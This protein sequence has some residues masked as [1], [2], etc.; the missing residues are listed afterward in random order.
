[1]PD[2]T[3]VVHEPGERA[4]S[5]TE[6][7]A[8]S[9][10]DAGSGADLAAWALILGG[11]VIVLFGA[12]FVVAI[13]GFAVGLELGA[14]IVVPAVAAQVAFVFVAW[15]VVDRDRATRNTVIT[16]LMVGGVLF[17]LGLGA[18]DVGDTSI[19]GRHYQGE[20]IH[21]LVDGWNPLRDPALQFRHRDPDIWTNSYPK[22]T[23]VLQ[24][25]VM[26]VGGDFEST[27]L[28]GAAL[29]AAS[30]LIA[31]A[32]FAEAG[33]NRVGATAG[34]LV[35]ALNPVATFELGTHMVDGILS[36]LLIATMLLALSWLWNGTRVVVIAPLLLGVLL[37]VNTKFT[38][39]VFAVLILGGTVLVGGLVRRTGWRRLGGQLAVLGSCIVVSVVAFGF[40]P[41]VT[42]AL[43]HDSPLYPVLGPNSRDITRRLTVGSLR[44][45]SSL[46]RLARSVAAESQPASLEPKVKL[47]LTF[48][49][50]E[51]SAFRGTGVRFGGFGPLFSG[52]LLVSVAG[53]FVLAV[54]LWR[55]EAHVSTAAWMILVA[56][57]WSL[58]S[59]LVMP[60]AFVARFAP[61]LWF[62]PVLVLT[63]LL[64]VK[65]PTSAVPKVLAVIAWIGISI[66]LVNA[67]GVAS[68]SVRW[69][70][71]DS[72]R[73]DANLARLRASPTGY[74]VE[75]GVWRQ[76][77]ARR[78]RESGVVFRSVPRVQCP[79]PLWLRI[80]GSLTQ[81]T[82]FT[83]KRPIQGAV[84]CP[85]G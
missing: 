28:V 64:L 34:A 9:R 10:D 7:A 52:G 61:Q 83:V 72:D 58:L 75:F 53:A 14:R 57:G 77:E 4:G 30:A 16:V 2:R 15:R 78:L 50:R 65:S 22:A 63:A 1:M 54:L 76:A 73:Q 74:D 56:A 8:G 69:D 29:L 20:S 62:V 19:D 25:T 42:N 70:L 55:K 37:L 85:R 45:Q 26:K 66:L 3:P 82:V 81:L 48:T 59:V 79:Y 11:S 40:N 23:W 35:L 6:P 68:S 41:Y 39:A 33:L 21:A 24:A 44:E 46:E 84:L 36:S 17:G 27:K 43:R 38:G 5:D 49:V 67:V 80:E 18:S 31:F 60:D 12:V 13:A 47:P 32:C 51:W 71:R